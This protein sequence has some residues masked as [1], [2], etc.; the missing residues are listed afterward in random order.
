MTADVS[1]AAG[2]AAD[3]EHHLLLHMIRQHLQLVLLR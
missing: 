2:N 3:Q 1:D